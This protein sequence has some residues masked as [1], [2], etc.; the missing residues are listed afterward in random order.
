MKKLLILLSLSLTFFSCGKAENTEEIENKKE[1]F[2]IELE[3]FK[4]FEGTFQIE[5][6][7]KISPSQDIIL[8]SKAGGRVSSIEVDFGEEV[9]FGKRLINLIDNVSNYGLNLE[10][11]SLSLEG[12]KLNYEANKISL[13]KIVGD[14]KNNLEKIEQDYSILEKTI[15]ENE[16]SSQLNLDQSQIY[17]DVITSSSIQLDKI[18]N[19]IKKA[20]LDYK[21]FLK[22]NSE[23]VKAFTITSKNDFINLKNIYSDVIN[24]G[25]GLLGVTKLNKKKNDSFEDYLGLKDSIHLKLTEEKLLGLIDYKIENLSSVDGKSMQEI[26]ILG[27]EAYPKVISFL[28]NLY[29]VLDNSVENIYFTDVKISGYK[30]QISSYKTS[31]SSYYTS[32]LNT[33]PSKDKFLNTYKNLEESNFEQIELLKKIEYY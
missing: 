15:L 12:A 10:K 18:D 19:S 33:K 27:E 24:L 17:G 8:S 16:K 26:Y 28:N 1:S 31:S 3:L 30:T 2:E 5:K 25:D 23:Q 14:A 32:F 7:G 13:D 29:L 9:L 4:N 20:E 22:S 6:T 11:T 21:N